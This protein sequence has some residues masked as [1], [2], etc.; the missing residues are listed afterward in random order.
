M[1]SDHGADVDFCAR[2]KE[3]VEI[4]SSYESKGEIN[5]A[6]SRYGER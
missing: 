4:L 2:N 5:G 1:L 6:F 3:A